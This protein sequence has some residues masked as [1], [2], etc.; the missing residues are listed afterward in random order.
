[1]RAIPL[2]ASVILVGCL[3]FLADSE[4]RTKGILTLVWAVCCAG[5]FLPDLGILFAVA[6]MVVDGILWW[7]TFGGPARHR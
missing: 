6:L 3:W 5:F 2:M 4:A 7:V 1:M